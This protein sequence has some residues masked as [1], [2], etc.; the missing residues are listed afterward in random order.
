MPF[1]L[2]SHPAIGDNL[3]QYDKLQLILRKRAD[4][5]Q[6]KTLNNDVR[7]PQLGYGVWKVPNEEAE[8]AVV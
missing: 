3:L 7:I 5:M 2:H 8:A 1:K 6:Y 4:K